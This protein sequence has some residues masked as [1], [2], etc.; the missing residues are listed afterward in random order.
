MEISNN[1]FQIANISNAPLEMQHSLDNS[2][3]II[4]LNSNS[5][6]LKRIY[7]KPNLNDPN[8]NIL[9]KS[10]LSFST[11]NLNIISLNNVE[12]LSTTSN[13]NPSATAISL[14]NKPANKLSTGPNVNSL[15][16]SI[17]PKSTLSSSDDS[18]LMND[19]FDSPLNMKDN[20]L[21]SMRKLKPSL[22]GLDVLRSSTS[23]EDEGVNE[24]NNQ[25][26]NNDNKKTKLSQLLTGAITQCDNKTTFPKP[27]KTQNLLIINDHS[28]LIKKT[29]KITNKVNRSY[30]I[31]S[32]NS[33][34]KINNSPTP[35][36]INVQ[37]NNPIIMKQSCKRGKEEALS[38]SSSSDE[39]DSQQRNQNE[40]AIFIDK[41]EHAKSQSVVKTTPISIKP[42][43]TSESQD[44]YPV[45]TTI[46]FSSN[47][48]N[49]NNTNNI[50]TQAIIDR[51][52][53]DAFKDNMINIQSAMKACKSDHDY[54][55]K[56]SRETLTHQQIHDSPIFSSASSTASYSSITS[57]TSPSNTN[58]TI[59]YLDDN[60]STASG[61]IYVR[62][63]G[64]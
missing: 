18:L 64:N 55:G 46:T 20:I 38:N 36:K 56:Y 7:L 50:L 29:N 54:N 1:V 62:Q 41:N 2:S 14:I 15:P 53:S 25:V 11:K 27:N 61:P 33:N 40:Y 21:T 32:K 12:P 47:K 24:S 42:S 19:E 30:Y 63:P 52:T 45:L 44:S 23:D 34:D 49:S 17:L 60:S 43:M 9:L 3:Q 39:D 57:V 13:T 5:S 59:D 28:D 35:T 4:S 6:Q 58:E 48:S 22:V 31:S 37:S 16:S 26:D 10:R 8:S 51:T